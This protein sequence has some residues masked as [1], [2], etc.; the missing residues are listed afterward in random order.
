[1]KIW[2][3]FLKGMREQLRDLASLSMVLVLCP[4]FVLLYWMMSSGGSTT[5][6]ILVLNQDTPITAQ[7]L[8]AGLQIVSSI[9]EMRYP[10]G[11]SMA[12][13]EQISDRAFADRAL[14]NRNA[15]ALLI[16]PP[17]LSLVL[18]SANQ[19]AD[20]TRTSVTIVGD[21]ANPAYTV[22]SIV[23]LTAADHVTQIVSG[24]RPLV[25]WKEV[26][27]S[28]SEPR[29]EFEVYVPGLLILSV[30]MLLFTTAL[31]LVRERE[32]KTLRRFRLS[33]ASSFDL[34]AG[35]S[36]TQIVIGT[37]SILLTFYTAIAL[38]FRCVG[39]LWSA[40]VVGIL[41]V[42][43]VIALGIITAC[44]CKNATAVL[45]IGTLPFFLLMWFT[46]AAMPLPRAPL[47]M[48]AGREIAFNDLLPPTHAVIAMNKIVSLGASLADVFPEMTA[49]MGLSIAYFAAGVV[50]FKKTQL[51]RTV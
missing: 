43:S 20:S 26:F 51:Q 15:A 24:Y 8:H 42:G 33:R 12:V 3:I 34:L 28:Q 14:R 2:H 6:K 47:F 50:L 7:H 21:M 37:V 40:I 48:L 46:G 38:G 23:A 10:N 1:M 11:Q 36:L 35:I 18:S 30:I 45:T 9:K 29:T 32:H 17:D 16:I 13:V 44:F 25:G 41:T 4:F 31:A 49:M 19:I 27:L 5:Y 39:S 22:A